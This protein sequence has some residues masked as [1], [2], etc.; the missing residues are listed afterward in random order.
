M[1]QASKRESK[2]L[3]PTSEEAGANSSPAK[4]NLIEIPGTIIVKELADLLQVSAVDIIKSLMRNS[5]MANIN[6]AVDYKTAAAV[7]AGFGYEAH[8]MPQ[9]GRKSSSL[10]REIKNQQLQQG[11][12]PML[13]A[14]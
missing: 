13:S 10:I 4:A 3:E 11:E 6:Q 9:T 7:A 14:C 1:N 2:V 5:I 8:L 12:A